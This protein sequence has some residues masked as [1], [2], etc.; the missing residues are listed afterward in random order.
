MNGSSIDIQKLS[1]NYQFS[2]DPNELKVIL[3]LKKKIFLSSSFEDVK[4]QLNEFFKIQKEFNIKKI[5]WSYPEKDPNEEWYFYNSSQVG[6][7]FPYVL[8]KK[9]YTSRDSFFIFCLFE[10]IEDYFSIHENP[11]MA[12]D[13]MIVLQEVFTKYPYPMVLMS[14]SGDVLLFNPE[15]SKLDMIPQNLKMIESGDH[16]EVSGRNFNIFKDQWQ[17]EDNLFHLYVFFSIDNETDTDKLKKASTAD[18]GIITSS[19]AHELNNPIAG[20]GAA[21]AYLL[22]D[23]DLETSTKEHL[24]E[25]RNGAKRCRELIEIFLGFSKR[26]QNKPSMGLTGTSFERSLDLIRHR[27]VESNLCLDFS[28]KK[29]N[30]FKEIN[31][32][33]IMAM[34]FYS[35]LNEVLTTVGQDR[36]INPKIGN[37]LKGTFTE[38]SNTLEISL[39]LEGDLLKNSPKLMANLLSL[40]GL[41]LTSLPGKI[42]ISKI[43]FKTNTFTQQQFDFIQ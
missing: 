14:G 27:M 34:I 12:K 18:L 9:N 22:L 33:S 5:E 17:N 21:I 23:E 10:I 37:S 32:S 15:F 13:K 29:L 26:H 30:P 19:L 35:I 16:L 40:E 38:D 3:E 4:N 24:K 11:S 31:N 20:I 6:A 43:A 7:T 41:E 36:L 2:K 42:L 25:M 1:M 28:F 8:F 39:N